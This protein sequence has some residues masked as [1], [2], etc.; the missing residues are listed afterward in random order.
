MEKNIIYLY[1][2][3]YSVGRIIQIEVKGNADENN[4][5]DILDHY[6]LKES[7]CSYM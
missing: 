6:N 3:E 7:E 2:L 1:V 4:I 5:N